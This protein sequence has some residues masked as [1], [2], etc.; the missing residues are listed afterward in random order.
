MGVAR[1]REPVPVFNFFQYGK[2]YPLSISSRTRFSFLP[3]RESVPVF[4][5][6]QYGKPYLSQYLPVP[7]FYFFPYGNA[8][9]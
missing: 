8:K 1:V 4:N 9:G 6:F 7:V 5:Y 3:V 2:L